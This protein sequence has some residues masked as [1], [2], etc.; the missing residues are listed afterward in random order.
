MAEKRPNIVVI[1]ADQFRHDMF[2]YADGPFKVN[3]PNIDKLA[4]KG[5]M[6]TNAYSANP[7]CMPN[8]ASIAT[9]RWP[10]VH[11]TR[12]NG[13]T[14]DQNAE[15]FMRTLRRSGY[16]NYA[17]KAWVGLGKITKSMKCD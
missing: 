14:F 8:R 7:T 10:S 16:K 3:T 15:T 12:T 11:G 2:S 4:K 1:I 6:F 9:G 13:V 17:T 5:V